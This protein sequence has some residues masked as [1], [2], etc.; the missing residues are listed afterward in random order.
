MCVPDVCIANHV[1]EHARLNSRPS[2]AQPTA[3]GKAQY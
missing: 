2:E 3:A 1:P